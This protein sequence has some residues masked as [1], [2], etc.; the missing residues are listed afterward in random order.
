MPKAPAIMI[1]VRRISKGA[2][3]MRDEVE[4]YKGLG[5]CP[6]VKINQLDLYQEEE[7]PKIVKSRGKYYD[8]FHNKLHTPT[9]RIMWLIACE[10]TDH[11]PDMSAT[12]LC[13]RLNNIM[14]NLEETNGGRF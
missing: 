13:N 1:I 14:A 4:D 2:F 9:A 10:L 8:N 3:R 6:R 11:Y 7:N 5:D 12:A